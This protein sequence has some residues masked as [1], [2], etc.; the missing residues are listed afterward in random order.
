MSEINKVQHGQTHCLGKF[1]VSPWHDELMTDFE[2]LD[3]AKIC[4][5]PLLWCFWFGTKSG[6]HAHLDEGLG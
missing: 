4:C 3:R 1:F 2:F 5:E 6:A